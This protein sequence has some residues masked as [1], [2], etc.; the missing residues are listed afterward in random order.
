MY[1]N[2]NNDNNNKKTMITIVF[3]LYIYIYCRIVTGSLTSSTCP[4]QHATPCFSTAQPQPALR[5]QL[6]AS[7]IALLPKHALQPKSYG[8]NWLME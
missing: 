4:F 7:L 5:D 8:D 3:F 1:N 6:E 2:D